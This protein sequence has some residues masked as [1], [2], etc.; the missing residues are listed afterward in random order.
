M[1]AIVSSTKVHKVRDRDV[2]VSYSKTYLQAHALLKQEQQKSNNRIEI[3]KD[4]PPKCVSTS[5]FPPKNEVSYTRKC[6]TSV[7]SEYLGKMIEAS[8]SQFKTEDDGNDSGEDDRYKEGTEMD[9]QDSADF[10]DDTG[11]NSDDFSQYKAIKL[12]DEVTSDGGDSDDFSKY[13]EIQLDDEVNNSTNDDDDSYD[14]FSKYKPIEMEG[15]ETKSIEED[16]DNDFSKYKEIELEDEATKTSC[17]GDDDD[18]DGSG[19]NCV[20]DDRHC[21]VSSTGSD[22]G[23]DD[24]SIVDSDGNNSVHEEDCW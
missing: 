2:S 3:P 24:N 18:D 9:T 19:G 6:K 11:D 21:G 5:A 1:E 7:T 17:G 22:G 23:G 8:L 20:D 4:L 16:D 12:K 15:E 10:N 13:K 14:D